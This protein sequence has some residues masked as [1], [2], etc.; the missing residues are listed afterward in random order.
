M[1]N[2]KKKKI[3]LYLEPSTLIITRLYLLFVNSKCDK[4]RWI[5]FGEGGGRGYWHP[6]PHFTLP[7]AKALDGSLRCT[8]N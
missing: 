6:H 7:Y 8:L 3:F 5:F 2:M 4:Y 1:T